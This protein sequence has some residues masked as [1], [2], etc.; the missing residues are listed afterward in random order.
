[1]D[2]FRASLLMVASMGIFAVED[3]LIKRAADHLPVGQIL[4]MLGVAGFVILAVFAAARGQTVFART[5]LA[6]AVL[7]RNLAELIG[8]AG[9]VTALA[10]NPITVASVILQASPLVVTMGAAL[11]LGETVGWRRWTAILVGLSGVIV[12]LRPGMEGFRVEA[13]WAVLG[14]LGLSARDIAT[15]RVPAGVT[16]LQISAWAFA[17][18]AVAGLATLGL[19]ADLAVPPARTS[20]ELSG[21]VALGLAGYALL[22]MAVRGGDL[23]VVAPFRYSRILFALIV[24]FLIFGERPDWPMAV[25][26]ALIVGSGL[27]TLVRE[28]RLRR[29]VAAPSELAP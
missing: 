7:I 11:F 18:V 16:T 25:G 8:T 23:A 4:A 10:L 19:G 21:A 20:V 5:F 26:A 28:A 17:A 6:P 2:N 22:T 9:F 15:R 24:G 13:L 1:M 14:V 12:I 27:Y 29:R 3:A